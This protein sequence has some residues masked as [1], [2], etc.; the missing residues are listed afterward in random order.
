[1]GDRASG[2]NECLVGEETVEVE[3]PSRPRPVTAVEA[4][5]I[6][7]RSSGGGVG[8]RGGIGR[9]IEEAIVGLCGDGFWS[10]DNDAHGR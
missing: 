6:S 8:V 1:M 3:T 2:S 9:G 5:D 10:I 4:V 7:T